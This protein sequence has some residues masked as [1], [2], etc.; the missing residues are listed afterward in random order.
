MGATWDSCVCKQQ[1]LVDLKAWCGGMAHSI[2]VPRTVAKEHLQSWMAGSQGQHAA[3]SV[4]KDH[5]PLS[6][7]LPWDRAR[8][9]WV[10]GYVTSGIPRGK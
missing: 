1:S 10:Q 8:H 6:S 7:Y 9:S 3:A 2:S 5:R 4:M